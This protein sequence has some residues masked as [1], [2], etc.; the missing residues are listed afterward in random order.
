MITKAPTNVFVVGPHSKLERNTVVFNDRSINEC[1]WVD[2]FTGFERPDLR[3]TAQENAQE[4]GEIPDPAFHGGRTMTMSGTIRARAYTALLEMIAAFE[5][6]L[7]DLVEMP[8]S[9]S[10][11]PPY[12]T[13]ETLSINCRPVDYMVD[14]KLAAA[15]L[16][17]LYRRPFTVALRASD[18][19]Y[20]SLTLQHAA[21]IPSV[22]NV[23]GRTY[24]RTYD[25]VYTTLLDSTYSPAATGNTVTVQ[26]N[27][28]WS[29]KPIIRFNGTIPAGTRLTNSANG[30]EMT[31]NQTIAA[32]DYIEIDIAAGTVKDS[33]GNDRDSYLD[34]HSDWMML[35]GRRGVLTG[36]NVL[37]LSLASFDGNTSCE[38]WWRDT[39]L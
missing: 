38:I 37:A 27:G 3:V 7:L 36:T 19:T 26:N 30:H 12:I 2:E 17:G 28:N 32:G 9:I 34:H 16:M 4:D 29:A 39:S 14:K 18:P 10:G 11:T 35:I 13:H 33:L 24:D 5:D 22:I 15:D 23:L 1:Y 6:S 8:L 25:L 31:I 21:I 20:Q